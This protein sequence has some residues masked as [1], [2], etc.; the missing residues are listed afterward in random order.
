MGEEGTNRKGGWLINGIASLQAKGWV[1]VE[2]VHEA[3]PLARLVV[4][5]WEDRLT[6]ISF[7]SG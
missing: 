1:T 4:T 3:I 2:E 5:E 6:V 7:G